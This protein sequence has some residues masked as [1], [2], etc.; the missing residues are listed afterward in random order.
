VVECDLANSLLFN[1]FNNLNR[2][3]GT[4]KYLIIRGGQN[5]N[6]CC[7]GGLPTV[8]ADGPPGLPDVPVG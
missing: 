4:A 7:N 5:Q 2:L 1:T 3:P 6:G 8:C